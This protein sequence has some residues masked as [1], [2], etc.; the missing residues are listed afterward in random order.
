M[1]DARVCE[2]PTC[3][4]DG[5]VAALLRRPPALRGDE[6]AARVRGDV[7]AGIGEKSVDDG[8]MSSF[9]C[10]VKR[11]TIVRRWVDARVGE[12]HVDATIV[13]FPFKLADES[14]SFPFAEGS[15]RG[16]SRRRRRSAASSVCFA[17]TRSAGYRLGLG[18][19]LGLG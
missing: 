2:E 12:E 3:D 13:S 17:A 14:A 4:C 1:R 7:D 5:L 19:G 10:V 9:D 6:R 8:R 16:S 15:T 18:L 11:R